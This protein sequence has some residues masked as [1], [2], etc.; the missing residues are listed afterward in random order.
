MKSGNI[1]NFSFVLAFVCGV[2]YN[3]DGNRS[4]LS[5]VALI[6]GFISLIWIY[7]ALQKRMY[8]N[9]TPSAPVTSFSQISL[10]FS[11]LIIF[12]V[13]FLVGGGLGTAAHTEVRDYELKQALMNGGELQTVP[14]SSTSC[15]IVGIWK[16]MGRNENFY[17]VRQDGTIERRDYG[18]KNFYS[19]T[20]GST[21]E[22]HYEFIWEPGT[23]SIS[24]SLILS[25]ARC[26]CDR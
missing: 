17:V 6:G 20:W 18:K 19:G 9:A 10:I 5:S 16:A 7:I 12:G 25:M 14:T 2:V 13:L 8:A 15:S 22:K 23:L 26:I 21:G 11:P 1:H 24:S 4:S 3:F